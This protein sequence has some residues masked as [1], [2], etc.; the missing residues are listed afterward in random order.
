MIINNIVYSEDEFFIVP[1]IRAYYYIWYNKTS[2]LL[3]IFYL[4]NISNNH[5]CNLRNNINTK[6]NDLLYF[7]NSCV[8]QSIKNK[9]SKIIEDGLKINSKLY[10]KSDDKIR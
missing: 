2:S 6:E 10:C 7:Y 8:K 1:Y 4:E 5:F 3:K 9:M